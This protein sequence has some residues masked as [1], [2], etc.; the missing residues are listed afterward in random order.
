MEI[1]DLT[2]Y[3]VEDD[4]PMTRIPRKVQPSNLQIKTENHVDGSLQSST[5]GTVFD[6]RQHVTVF[7]VALA[8]GVKY[9]NQVLSKAGRSLVREYE[10]KALGKTVEG[11]FNVNFFDVSDTLKIKFAL[12]VHSQGIDNASLKE[13]EAM[14]KIVN[15]CKVMSVLLT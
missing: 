8:T 12:A 5:M 11:R 6:S 7:E 14:D 3:D 13:I 10:C 15:P 9:D 1:V 2:S 4:H